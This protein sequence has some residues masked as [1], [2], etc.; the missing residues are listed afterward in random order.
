SPVSLTIVVTQAL[1]AAEYQVVV[2][3]L[4]EAGRAAVSPQ[5]GLFALYAPAEACFYD[6]F[7]SGAGRWTL[8]GAWG[9]VTL[10]GG[11]HAITD[12]PGG[13]YNSAISPTLTLTSAITSAPFSL[14]GC[15]LPLLTFRHDYVI[16]SLE[17]SRDTAQ[18]ELSTDDGQTW[19]TLSRYTGGGY[20]GPQVLPR[21]TDD[22]SEWTDVNWKTAE[23]GL[24]S[25]S[26]TL[27][28][29]PVRLRLSLNVDQAVSD[30]G[31]VIDDL[32]VVTGTTRATD[33]QLELTRRGSGPVTAGHAITYSLTI[34]GAGPDA[35]DAL[36]SGLFP[37]GA[38][39]TVRSSPACG[40]DG[41]LWCRFDELTGSRVITLV[42]TP[43]LT[44]SGTLTTTV[45]IT[46]TYP[47][48]TG[49]DPANNR[50]SDAV[51]V[52]GPPQALYLPLILKASGG[53]GIEK[54][55]R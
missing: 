49:D 45:A 13:N 33:L 50:A 10:P 53:P 42:L 30:R 54:P 15:P 48:L 31:W 36:V 41:A 47:Y 24:A 16:A 32:K 2:A 6:F 55:A 18:V 34:T 8:D 7:E 43:S 21:Q 19:H 3:N 9:I 46:P 17:G 28:T 12:S 22:G 11:E 20:F 27:H 40:V 1:P 29:G 39:A 37:A 52:K 14:D 4:N 35:T 44:Y 5:P 38:A 26:G 51:E 25:F 23:I